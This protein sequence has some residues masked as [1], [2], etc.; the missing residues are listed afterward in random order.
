MDTNS[1]VECTFCGLWKKFCVYLSTIIARP[2]SAGSIY[3]HFTCGRSRWLVSIDFF[4]HGQMCRW[5]VAESFDASNDCAT[6][7]VF[8]RHMRLHDEISYLLLD[9]VSI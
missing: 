4:F 5:D 3:E 7:N 1:D 9:A 8:V 2:A 6:S